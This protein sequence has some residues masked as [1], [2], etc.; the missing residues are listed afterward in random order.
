MILFERK[1][2]SGLFRPAPA[3]L[4]GLLQCGIGMA[5]QLVEAQALPSGGDQGAIR[6]EVQIRLQFALS[7]D[8][9]PNWSV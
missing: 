4:L 9:M 8:L 7:A 1:S 3:V 2:Q 6:V 5:G